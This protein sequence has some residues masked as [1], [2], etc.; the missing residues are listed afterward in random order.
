MTTVT[1]ASIKSTID[2]ALLA[3]NITGV[4]VFDYAR[5]DKR[6]IFPSIEITPTTAEQSFA[7]EKITNIS[8]GLNIILRIKPRGAGT[9]DV[10]LQKSIEDSVL[11]AITTT[12]LGQT[13]LH[14]FNKTWQ[15]PNA[16]VT[17]PVAHLQSNL[18]VLITT[19]T[20]STGS[21]QLVSEM[22]V[23]FPSLAGM[24]LLDK[25]V[26]QEIETGESIKDDTNVRVEFGMITDL[27]RTFFE[28]EYTDARITTLRTQRK[29]RAKITVTLHRTSGDDVMTGKISSVNH[30]GTLGNI[31][32]I[33]IG[34]EV[35]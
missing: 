18:V 21:G 28:I 32:T 3:S 27:R 30:G 2:A 13:R 31:E 34:F 20:S 14:I 6:K 19:D 35:F 15:R 23:D 1:A 16:L 5:P 26:E 25:P 11:A 17:K 33:I 4:S 12:S 10:T 24:K 9:D 7:D 29:A 22:T 8:Q